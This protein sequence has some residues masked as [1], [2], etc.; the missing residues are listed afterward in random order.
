MSWPHG[1]LMGHVRDA[2]GRPVADATVRVLS[3]A[4]DVRV[5]ADLAGSRDQ[6]SPKAILEQDDRRGGAV[7]T[8]NSS[9]F[10]RACWLPTNTP[11]Q[12]AVLDDDETLVP[13]QH[14]EGPL[15]ANVVAVA[16]RAITISLEEPHATLDLRTE[17]RTP[18]S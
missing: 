17:R 8:T 15:M 10:Y 4:Y 5:L 9:G 2:E 3:D 6:R 12:V 14:K 11:L 1:I 13:G 16:E 7:V 18:P